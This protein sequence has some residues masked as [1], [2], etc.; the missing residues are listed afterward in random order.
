ME[1]TNLKEKRIVV[2]SGR[3]YIDIDAYAACVAYAKLL[4]KKGINA[5][6]ISTAEL[7]ESI[8]ESI[9]GKINLLEGTTYKVEKN[10]KF[11]ILDVSNKEFFDTFVK[12]DD[13]VEIID[14]HPG[15]EEFWRD[16]LQEHSI[17]EEVGA[18]ATV[19]V[20]K[21]EEEDLL[22]EIDKNDAYLLMAAILDNTLNFKAK[23]TTQRDINA[24][25]RLLSIV[26][27]DLEFAQRYFF[28][29]DKKIKEDL[30]ST[31][32]SATKI[33]K[34][35]DNLPTNFSQ[36][37]VWE[38]EWLINRK[39]EIYDALDN[40]DEDWIL[41]IICLKD[42]KSYIMSK[43]NSAKNKVEKLFNIQFDNNIAELDGV[44]LRK[45][46]MKKAIKM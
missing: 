29:C 27:N 18:V 40:L 15:F 8:P 2:T 20:E 41:N 21:Y 45:E 3:K 33:E 31:T 12:I 44:W 13:I 6:T 36:L 22:K 11:I 4:N 38:K 46:I 17:I 9:F 35:S 25:K 34:V 37:V 28:E 26:D 19:I 5:I 1:I 10:D 14:H 7:N 43:N 42:G 39:E 23:I 30:K 24:Y 16:R 32:I